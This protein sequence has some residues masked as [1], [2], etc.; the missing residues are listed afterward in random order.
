MS[1]VASR[2]RASASK[3][4]LRLN[5]E[6]DAPP[7]KKEA[8]PQADKLADRA[9]NIPSIN[10]AKK[11][12]AAIPK[13]MTPVEQGQRA[14]ARDTGGSNG[15]APL[16]RTSANTASAAIP[17][18]LSSVEM[19][20]LFKSGDVKTISSAM[21]QNLTPVQ[22]G[23]LARMSDV[24]TTGARAL[25]SR[26]LN[27]TGATAT[28]TNLTNVTANQI[29]Q[30]EIRAAAASTP[31]PRALNLTAVQQSG[32]VP[33]T[34]TPLSTTNVNNQPGA[35]NSQPPTVTPYAYSPDGTRTETASPL[36]PGAGSSPQL[37]DQNGNPIPVDQSSPSSTDA[38]QQPRYTLVVGDGDI[39]PPSGGLDNPYG[40]EVESEVILGNGDIPYNV[41]GDSTA[42]NLSTNGIIADSEHVK[43]P[44]GEYVDDDLYPP[45]IPGGP[46]PNNVDDP[47]EYLAKFNASSREEQD[48]M[49]HPDDYYDLYSANFDN[50]PTLTWVDQGPIALAPPQEHIDRA[51][52]ELSEGGGSESITGLIND[53]N[54]FE[55][56]LSTP[57]EAPEPWLEKWTQFQHAGFVTVAENVTPE[58]AFNVGV[59]EGVALSFESNAL[60]VAEM[61]LSTLQFG[62]DESRFGYAGDGL[63]GVTGNLPKWLDAFIPSEERGEETIQYTAQ[64]TENMAAYVT[65]RAKDPSLFREDMN[66]F[67]SEHW[68]E[69]KDD[70]AAA[71]AQ[72]PQ[73]EAEWWG[74][75]AGQAAVEIAMTAVAAADVVK[76]AKAT[77]GFAKLALDAGVEFTTT[78]L[79]EVSAY[80]QE[81]TSAANTATASE[82]LS[83]TSYDELKE[84]Q[85]QL[86]EFEL[87]GDEISPAT[88]EGRQA[89]A[90]LEEAQTAV[91]NAIETAE[92]LEAPKS[93]MPVRGGDDDAGMFTASMNLFREFDG[94]AALKEG[95]SSMIELPAGTTDQQLEKYLTNLTDGY[96]VE[97]A[98][99]RRGNKTVLLR[100]DEDSIDL[101]QSFKNSIT[102]GINKNNKWE[103]IFHT[104]SGYDENAL[105]ASAA[106]QGVLTLLQQTNPSKIINSRGQTAEFTQTNAFNAASVSHINIKTYQT[107]AQLFRETGYAQNLKP[108]TQYEFNGRTYKTDSRGRPVTAAGELRLQP[109]NTPRLH[110]N[111][112]TEIG[113]SGRPKVNGKYPD[114]GFH[115]I[116][117]QFDA[118]V[119]YLNVVAGDAKLNGNAVGK[120]GALENQLAKEL[121]AGKRV[122]VNIELIYDETQTGT[123]L[124]RR[125]KTFVYNYRISDAQGNFTSPWKKRV[126]QNK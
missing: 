14:R 81:L 100:G 49:P 54:L 114:V 28:P 17:R 62:A 27:L 38:Q 82:T 91:N 73:A 101:P 69:L 110:T 95:N 119:N 92:R 51:H 85:K 97:F 80:A 39:P 72:G 93:R 44:T 53:A 63:R 10:P 42:N 37:L 125:P 3:V 113:H 50:H 59:A 25:T 109:A 83:L 112:Q 107:E 5:R 116:G 23:E 47:F 84:V 96:G 58:Q 64:L 35:I 29:A 20:K 74:K 43:T 32:A 8:R 120:Y 61:A 118:E 71:V 1:S 105:K 121:A 24:A 6:I 45:N 18:K 9:K 12:V 55:A 66:K 26:A 77:A 68:E 41:A 70:H 11:A 126:F 89:L 78:K 122:E 79:N 106:D 117:H 13:K 115:L 33:L 65:T 46:D 15:A 19:G 60:G 16:S 31:T 108:Y 30:T 98:V 104:Q 75:M 87:F 124:E 2:L 34:P 123:A 94:Q 102:K 76:V 56:D 36:V 67:F 40:I 21:G 90:D 111:V 48:R 99:F 57:G 22:K 7:K 4:A 103:L 52:R 88:A 86:L